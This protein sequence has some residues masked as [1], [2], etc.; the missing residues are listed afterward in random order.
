MILIKHDKTGVPAFPQLASHPPDL[1]KEDVAR[2][3]S[4]LLVYIY[5]ILYATIKK[6]AVIDMLIDTSAMVSMTEANQNFSKVA[7]LADSKGAIIIMKNNAPKYILTEIRG[8][9]ED[10]ADDSVIDHISQQLMTRNQK[11]YEVLAK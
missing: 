5:P 3:L 8:D 4:L 6:K 7:K 1:K 9:R 2:T 10:I 11:A